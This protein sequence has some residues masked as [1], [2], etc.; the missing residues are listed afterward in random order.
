MTTTDP[1]S[2]IGS[3]QRI[4]LTPSIWACAIAIAVLRVEVNDPIRA[5]HRDRG[6]EK[7]LLND[8]QGAIGEIVAAIR[9]ERTYGVGAVTH[10]LVDFDGPVDDVD[11]KITSSSGEI[12]LETKCL[13]WEAN[14]KKFLINDKAHE[15]SVQR[16][17]RGYIPV[18]ASV[19]GNIA[20]VG[21]VI[22]IEEVANWD[23]IAYQYGDPAKGIDLES[24][25][26]KYLGR[27]WEK[28]RDDHLGTSQGAVYS[29]E[30]LMKRIPEAIAARRD[31]IAA[32]LSGTRRR[33]I[34]C[35]ADNVLEI[36]D[37]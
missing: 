9:A 33:R 30:A 35:I 23:R 12:R 34:E 5:E 2:L 20:I 32:I 16:K 1:L 27:S 10:D 18:L 26:E 15:R 37:Q 25:C 8:L 14:K 24:F 4:L 11:I 22:G 28:I 21:P 13:L 3:T 7:N 29:R 17:A 36:I 19:G 31:E 6:D